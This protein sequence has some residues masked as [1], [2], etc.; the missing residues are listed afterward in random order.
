MYLKK[1]KATQAQN[2]L[3]FTFKNKPTSVVIDPNYLL[4]DKNVEDNRMDL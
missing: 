1:H 2:K 4:I 3:S